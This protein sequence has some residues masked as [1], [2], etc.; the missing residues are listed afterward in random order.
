MKWLI[1]IYKYL[2][3]TNIYIPNRLVEIRILKVW[4]QTKTFDKIMYVTTKVKL[5]F[6]LQFYQLNCEE[7][8]NL[9]Y[10]SLE[11]W[12]SIFPILVM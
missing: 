6:L 4:V 12:F 3:I 1:C 2:K 10:G 5:L 9:K 8:Q 11:H 7:D